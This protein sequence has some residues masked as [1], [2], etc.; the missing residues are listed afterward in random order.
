MAVA[1]SLGKLLMPLAQKTCC[2]EKK[3]RWGL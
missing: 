3:I 1:L 2:K